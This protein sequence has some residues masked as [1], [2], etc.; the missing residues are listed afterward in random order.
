MD[1]L[2]P[3]QGEPSSIAVRAREQH[4]VLVRTL[5]FRG[6]RT[7]ELDAD[8]EMPF[9]S[10]VGDLATVFPKGAVLMR[11]TDLARRVEVARVERALTN[12]GVPILGR[13]A[14]PGLLDGGDVMLGS[15]A[16]Y[17]GVARDRQAATGI[18]HRRG[19]NEFGRR[20]L[21][22]FAENEG[23][24]T[25]E[26]PVASDVPRLRSVAAFVDT[27]TLLVAPD[28]V[29]VAPFGGMQ[30]IEAPLGEEYACGVIALGGRRLIVNLRFRTIV[31]ILR[32]AKFSID[33]IDLWEFGKIGAT[34]SLLALALAR[35]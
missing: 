31:S 4:Q 12:L 6:V 34:P 21:A 11:P 25:I 8:P 10:L 13:I 23:F 28:L 27:D 1:G 32:K 2:Q 29:D 35:K 9:G 30:T 33:A 3:I 22:V 19:G 15:D 17:V 24:R 20:Q 16:V 26:V 5:S 18:P 14:A 7:I